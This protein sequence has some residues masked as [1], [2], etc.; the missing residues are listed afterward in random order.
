M[1]TV[2]QGRLKGSTSSGKSIECHSVSANVQS[3]KLFDQLSLPVFLFWDKLSDG[4]EQL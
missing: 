4:S 2:M 1:I 3:T